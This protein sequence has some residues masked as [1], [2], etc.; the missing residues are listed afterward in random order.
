MAQS[1]SFFGLRKGSTK[2]LTFSTYN[3]KQVTK[4]RVYNVKNPRSQA[5]MEQR[6]ISYTAI[7][8]YSAMKSICDHSFEGL[9]YGQKNMN[10]F[11]SLNTK[12]LSATRYDKVLGL[13]EANMPQQFCDYGQPGTPCSVIVSD[14]S[15]PSVSGL[16]KWSLSSSDLGNTPD[17]ATAYIYTGSELL[18]LLGVSEGDYVTFVQ[19]SRE[20]DDVHFAWVRAHFLAGFASASTRDAFNSAF[21][22][23]SA[24]GR[25]EGFGANLNFQTTQSGVVSVG[26][27]FTGDLINTGDVTAIGCAVI[28]S[29]KSDDSWL[30]SSETLRLLATEASAG[31]DTAIVT[32]PVGDSY[33]LNGGEK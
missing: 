30:R 26:L 21:S 29:H 32:W 11:L 25:V 22:V 16:F 4:D 27:A 28:A 9:S 19:F 7:K 12:R 31:F 2:S 33:I 15:L 17:A 24:G 8:A 10:R 23:E 6:M 20:A 1:K 14:G 5:Q 18:A 13:S 3:G